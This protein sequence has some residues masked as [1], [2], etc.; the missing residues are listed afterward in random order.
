MGDCRHP[1]DAHR[2]G[3]SWNNLL[4]RGTNKVPKKWMC[5]A[6]TAFEFRME[7]AGDK[8][9]VIFEFDEFNQA[10][11]DSP[12]KQPTQNPPVDSGIRH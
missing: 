5:F 8:P 3:V 12:P 6:G 1:R 4:G 7:L 9:G 2:S 10:R 11:L